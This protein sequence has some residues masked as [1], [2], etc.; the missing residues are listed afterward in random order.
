VPADF[1]L[2]IPQVCAPVSAS[3]SVLLPKVFFVS[4]SA[5][6]ETASRLHFLS[7][8]ILLPLPFSS[9]ADGSS[10]SCYYRQSGAEPRQTPFSGPNFIFPS[11]PHDFSSLLECLR[12]ACVESSCSCSV[13]A[14]VHQ[15][16]GQLSVAVGS[17]LRLCLILADVR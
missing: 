11:P 2:G 17:R 16:V 12:P 1:P 4:R 7:P 6:I 9:G 14:A 15:F 13:V 8:L 5:S 3:G 10:A